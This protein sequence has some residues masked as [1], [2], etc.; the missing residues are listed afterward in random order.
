MGD[1]LKGRIALIT[2]GAGGIGPATAGRFLEEDAE[3]VILVDQDG[4][5]A[6]AAAKELDPSGEKV[7]GFACD[8][9]DYYETEKVFGE[10]LARF[11][12]VDILVNNTDFR[13]KKALVSMTKEEWDSVVNA[14]LNSLF[15]T[16]RQICPGMKEREYGKIVNM[17]STDYLGIRDQTG[18]GASKAGV[19]GF[20]RSLAKELAKYN[21]T[22]NAVCPSDVMTAEFMALDPEVR[23]ARMNAFALKRAAYPEE[24]AA[25]IT[26][27]ASEDSCFVN[28]EK[29]MVTGGR[30]TS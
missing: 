21:I 16:C 2:G 9:A 26:F 10:I 24:I 4:G 11:G 20:T 27:L 6:Q 25:V 18:Y 12:R 22:V 14:D 29:I 19:L 1:M 3:K 30:V 7:F 13:R 28:G 17:S 15:N 23:E 5:A 8:V